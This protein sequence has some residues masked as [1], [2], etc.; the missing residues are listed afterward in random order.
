ML[1]QALV[2]AA[3][4]MV[5]CTFAC[6][7]HAEDHAEDH[8]PRHRV[9]FQAQVR[10]QIDRINGQTED[11][12][13]LMNRLSL[14]F[15]GPA[16][17][18]RLHY[19]LQTDLLTEP[20]SYREA[21]ISYSV[22]PEWSLKLG[23]HTIPFGLPRFISA[24]YRVFVDPSIAATQFEPPGSRGVGA[25]LDGAG[26]DNRWSLQFGLY[27]GRGPMVERT[28]DQG[29]HLASLRA[30]YA[31]SGEVVEEPAPMEIRPEADVVV[32]FGL[33]QANRN[34]QRDWSLGAF[35][36]TPEGPGPANLMSATAD[37]LWRDGPLYVSVAGFVEYVHLEQSAR[38]RDAGYEVEA[39][40][41]FTEIGS[42]QAELTLRRSQFVRDIDEE[43]SGRDLQSEI[44]AGV[45]WYQRGHRL[46]T[47]F[48]VLHRT[49]RNGEKQGTRYVL[50]QQ[51]RY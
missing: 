8:A 39:G 7:V 23:Q 34:V 17:A 26:A 1:I 51:L 38:Y 49:S 46:K 5:A 18:P 20:L 44:G 14:D 25:L 15:R 40:W 29:G 2:G 47:Q 37:V 22:S 36:A 11:G 35:A 19:R 9:L 12:D 10:Y 50:Q 13:L 43:L 21:W 27:D 33:M 31:L 4:G 6:N 42:R 3:F 41:V 45:N 30:M 24:P 48:D 28:P 16:V 32:G